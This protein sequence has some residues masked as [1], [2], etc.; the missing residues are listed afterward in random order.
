V[1][2]QTMGCGEEALCADPAR[3]RRMRRR[4]RRRRRRRR[5]VKGLRMITMIVT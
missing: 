5:D 2:K 3:R 1:E 4:K